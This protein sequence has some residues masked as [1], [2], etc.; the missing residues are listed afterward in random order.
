[1]ATDNFVAAGLLGVSRTD[2]EAWAGHIKMK[3]KKGIS[4]LDLA[5]AIYN[6]CMT[7]DLPTW[8]SLLVEIHPWV[9]SMTEELKKIAAESNVESTVESTV[10]SSEEKAPVLTPAEALAGCKT[11]KA[12]VDM[13]ATLGSTLKITMSWSMKV[14]REKVM[15]D[16]AAACAA[17]ATSEEVT[18]KK[19]EA[20]GRVPA[21]TTSP[22]PTPGQVAKAKAEAEAK[23]AAAKKKGGTRKVEDGEPCSRNS[24]AWLIWDTIRKS[25]AKGGISVKDIKERYLATFEAQ[26]EIKSSNPAGRVSPVM[27]WLKREKIIVPGTS[28][29]CYICNPE[30]PGK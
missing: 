13:A 22:D 5:E 18:E 20:P 3:I 26:T 28:D 1:M 23:A 17:Q 25:K 6:Y 19:T 16:L 8:D 29:G 11:K 15:E 14:M 2:L 30:W 24:T 27:G 21:D 4:D 9:N 12:I 10:E 7:C